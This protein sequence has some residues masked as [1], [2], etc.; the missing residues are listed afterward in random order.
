MPTKSKKKPASPATKAAHAYNEKKKQ[1]SENKRMKK[2]ASILQVAQ[3]TRTRRACV[4]DERAKTK[5]IQENL[6]AATLQRQ[7]L[8]ADG[9]SNI[10]E[11]MHRHKMKSIHPHLDPVNRLDALLANMHVNGSHDIDKDEDQLMHRAVSLSRPP[12]ALTKR[13]SRR[14]RERKKAFKKNRSASSYRKKRASKRRTQQ[15]NA[16]ARVIS[17]KRGNKRGGQR[18]K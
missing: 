15:K 6:R 1:D 5:K 7:P 13:M 8:P 14:N 16:R 3:R 4:R 9:P 12:L 17:K 18:K 2:A 11:V 10:H